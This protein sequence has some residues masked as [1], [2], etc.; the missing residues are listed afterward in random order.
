MSESYLVIFNSRS[1]NAVDASNRNKVIF[2]V[3]WET[4]LPKTFKSFNA[5]LH[6]NQKV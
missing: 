3:N 1:S 5:N 6:L 2:D 4:F